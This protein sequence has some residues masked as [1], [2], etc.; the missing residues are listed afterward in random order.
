[1]SKGKGRTARSIRDQHTDNLEA[2]Q[3]YGPWT[4]GEPFQDTGSASKFARKSRDDFERL[5]ADLGTGE[6]GVPGDVLVLWEI[7]RLARETG[8]G[9][10]IVD[11]C[12]EQGYLIHITSHERTYNP[13]NY[14]DRHE[15]I[16]GIADAEREARRLSK[17]TLRGLNSAAREGRPQGQVPFGYAR[18]Y[19]VIDRRPRPVAQH[20]HEV[21][22]PLVAELFVRVAGAQDN[23]LGDEKVPLLYSR[24]AK[25]GDQPLPETIYAIAKEWEERGIVSRDRVVDGEHV[26]GI[27]FS[28]QNLRSMLLRPAY[29][30]LRKHNGTIVRE[31]WKGYTPIISR[32]LFDRVQQILA[33]PSRR[34]YT[35]E[36]IRHVLSM[37]MRCGVCRRPMAVMARNKN[38]KKAAIGYQGH[39]CGHVWIPKEDTD[40]LIIGELDRFDP[41]TG[42]RLPPKLGVILTW[43]ANP[44]RHT[45]LRHRPDDDAKTK[46]MRTEL[47]QLNRELRLL[48]DAPKPATAL[49]RI[50][51]TKDIEEYEQR[52]A[53]VE[54]K[55]SKLTTPAPLAA[56]LPDEP[57]TDVVRWWQQTGVEKQRAIAAALLT[58][59]ML[60][61]VRIMPSP[62]KRNSVPVAERIAWHREESGV[63]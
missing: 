61:E 55:L 36:H 34:K 63:D 4:W 44:D 40:H 18:D 51:R 46:R 47:E 43:L 17:R 3:E 54:A 62:V 29:A 21:E 14:N 60:G 5:V 56:L 49:A 10:E 9:V 25:A 48:K 11:R 28:P 52:V 59:G 31:Q 41:E 16:T 23:R 53:Q 33:D 19:E 27:P 35:G 8:R 24:P 1:M 22:G 39:P 38:G 57:I 15:L 37:T 2:E 26:P 58:P 32:P 42:E 12:E 6:F 45:A 7:S 50:E 13:R 20:P 30:G